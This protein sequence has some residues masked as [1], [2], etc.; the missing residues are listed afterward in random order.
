MSGFD[1]FRRLQEL[2]RAAEQKRF[3][4]PSRGRVGC[5]LDWSDDEDEK[6]MLTIYG[7]LTHE[8][9]RAIIKFAASMDKRLAA[10]QP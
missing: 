10:S 5:R 9:L 2:L 8:D 7:K 1:Q 6:L 3:N 4:T